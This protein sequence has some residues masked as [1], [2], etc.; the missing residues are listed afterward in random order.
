V[1][2]IYRVDRDG[3][4]ITIIADQSAELTDRVHL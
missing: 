2:R 4:N 1:P 3:G